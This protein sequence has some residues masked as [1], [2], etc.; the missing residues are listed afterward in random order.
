M[1][2]LNFARKFVSEHM[3]AKRPNVLD[4][5]LRKHINHAPLR[6]D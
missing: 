2:A 5:T 3:Q 6:L 1:R 4:Y